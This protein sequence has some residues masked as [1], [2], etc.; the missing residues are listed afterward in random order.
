MITIDQAGQTPSGAATGGIS[1]AGRAR[2]VRWEKATPYLMVLPVLAL[3]GVFIYWPLLY[4]VYLSMLDWNFISPTREFV[5]AENF[6][7]LAR[8]DGF[9]E[10]LVNTA[11]YLLVLVPALVLLPLGVALLMWPIRRSRAQTAYRAVLFSPV[12][13]SFAVIAVVWLWIFNPSG[14]LL[15][16]AIVAAGGQGPEWLNDP[17]LAFWCVV[18]VAAWKMFGFNLVLYLAA[19]EAVPKDYLEAAQLDGARSW[20]LFRDVRFPLISPTFFFVLVVTFVFVSE[21]VFAAINVLTQG[22]PFGQTSNLFYYL[23]ER[24]F[25]FF[26]VGDASATALVLFVAVMGVTWLQF[27]FAEGRVHYG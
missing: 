19:L 20:A 9:R 4:S 21:E 17:D 24:G 26:Q 25:E 5:G 2:A 14:G 12:V 1:R 7:D 6:L 3:M 8:D 22:G 11:L 16:Q 18:A 27:R 10:A 15:N 23:Y 13:V